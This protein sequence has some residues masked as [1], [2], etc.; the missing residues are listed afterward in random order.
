MLSVLDCG[1]VFTVCIHVFVVTS[2]TYFSFR[3]ALDKG[4]HAAP[5]LLAK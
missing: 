1:Y 5:K 2:Y 3:L 4:A